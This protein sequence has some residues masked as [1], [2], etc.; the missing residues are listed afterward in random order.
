[1]LPAEPS[2]RSRALYIALPKVQFND[3]LSGKFYGDAE[4]G[5]GALQIGHHRRL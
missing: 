2:V 5:V 1:V 3:A 4:S